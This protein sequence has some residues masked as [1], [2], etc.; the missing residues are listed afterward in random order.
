[1]IA[2]SK[3]VTRR[4]LTPRPAGPG[5]LG[6]VD[7]IETHGLRLTVAPYSV[8]V[9]MGRGETLECVRIPKVRAEIATAERPADASRTSN[10]DA[11]C[12]YQKR[13]CAHGIA[14]LSTLTM[15]SAPCPLL[16]LGQSFTG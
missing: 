4:A 14:A 10:G 7:R 6:G 11:A 3:G 8:A 5:Q 13:T 1:M 16:P 9:V 12:N 15:T 2:R